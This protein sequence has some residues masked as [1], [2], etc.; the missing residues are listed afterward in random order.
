MRSG[1][2][3]VITGPRHVEVQEQ[4]VRDPEP[5]EVLIRT[6]VSGI[7]AGT[8]MNVYRGFAPQWRRREDLTTGL[9]APAETADFTYPLIYGYAN[10]GVV[11]E[12]G[13]AVTGVAPGD[14]VFSFSPH[15]EW[16]TV[17]A[18]QVTQ[19]PTLRAT[20]HGILLA[21]LNTA[22][23]GVLDA[24]PPLG[25][26][27]VVSGLGVIGLLAT[28]LLGQAGVGYLAGIDRSAFRRSLAARFGAAETFEPG[29][30]VAPAVRARTTNRGADIVLEVSGA[31][32]ALNEAIRIVGRNGLV[33]ALSWYAG[34]F[35]SLDL[36]GE[37]HHN[38]VRIRSSQVGE[39]NPD[40]GPLWSTERRGDM[41][42]GLLNV[43]ELDPLFTHRF[44][45]ELA[46]DAYDCVDQ[47]EEGLVQCLFTY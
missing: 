10:V 13:G 4:P 2:V 12:A 23:N 28:Q 35:E 34:T 8:E 31:A 5:H 44:P 33:V 29:P 43:L 26:A 39:V 45:I 47:L 15:Q 19:L 21:N 9:F 11:Q 7:S 38:R 22:L 14:R 3:V 42:L 24:N 37:F 17:D 46:A 20:E 30:N 36:G 16:S 32:P 41:A 18:A 40:L 25:A 6:E 27:V 1:K